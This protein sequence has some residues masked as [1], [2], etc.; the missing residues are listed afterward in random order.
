VV[1]GFKLRALYL[2]GKFLSLEP[3]CKSPP[4]LLEHFKNILSQ[5][6]VMMHT[7]NP[8][9]SEF[10]ASLGYIGK[11]HVKKKKSLNAV[12][13]TYSSSY[14]EVR[15]EDHLSPGIQGQLGQHSKTPS[16]KKKICFSDI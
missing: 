12:S 3:L 1:L 10:E 2:L 11:P 16:Q 15:E 6:G 13:Y 4:A 5:L 14:S 8:S 9:T 7:C